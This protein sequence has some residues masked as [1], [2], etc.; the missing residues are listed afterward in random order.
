MAQVTFKGN[1]VAVD[2]KV[3][4]VGS[5]APDF[6]LVNGK[7]EDVTLGAF[8]NKKKVLTI[9]PS[10][11]TPVCAKAAR[12]FHEK[13]AGKGDVVVLAISADLPFAQGRFCTTEG[14]DGVVALSCFRNLQFAKDYG[15]LISA[16]PLANITARAVLVL[17]GSNKVLH[18]ELVKEIADEP[19]YDAALAAL[20]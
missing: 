3:P 12:S 11:D 6:T 10:Y 2:G 1:P 18:A 14:L 15:V 19:N 5:Q 16:G 17:D 20:G 13:A 8:A 4:V 9:N 7:L